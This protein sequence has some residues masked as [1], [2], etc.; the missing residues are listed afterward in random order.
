M[1]TNE[2]DIRAGVVRRLLADGWKRRDLR[3][4][5]PL[6]TASSGGRADVLCLDDSY[7]GCIELKSGRDKFCNNAIREQTKPY[8]RSFDY[9]AVIID[10]WHLKAFKDA[11]GGANG[12]PNCSAVYHSSDDTIREYWR[13]SEPMIGLADKL[14]AHKSSTTSPVDYACL[15]WKAE[16][17]KALGMK[18][19]RCE[20]IAF[21]REEMALKDIRPLVIEQ[22][23]GRAHN[24]WEEAFWEKYDDGSLDTWLSV[25]SQL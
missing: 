3:F 9:V 14:F 24:K 15:L 23:R 20:A 10:E 6:S 25:C 22:L 13:D 2:Y 11:Y 21:V 4:E 12:Y 19:N 8:R 5:I 7:I 18:K 16:I 17:N 1:R